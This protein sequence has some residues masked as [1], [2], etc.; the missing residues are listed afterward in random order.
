MSESKSTTEIR[1]SQEQ[2][3]EDKL[4]K[5]FEFIMKIDRLMGVGVKKQGNDDD[6]PVALLSLRTMDLDRLRQR[7]SILPRFE[8]LEENEIEIRFHFKKPVVYSAQDHENKLFD[9]I[10]AQK[11][12]GIKSVSIRM[13]DDDRMDNQAVFEAK[14]AL[15]PSIIIKKVSQQIVDRLKK[16]MM[17][18]SGFESSLET[19]VETTFYFQ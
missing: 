1:D 11:E 19:A 2:A 16:R 13:Y 5:Y 15:D 17:K 14:F 8:S 10:I 4:F 6:T 9:Y 18:V 7:L 3:N 12:A